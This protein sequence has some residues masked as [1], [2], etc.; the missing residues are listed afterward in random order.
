M[1]KIKIVYLS[2]FVHE[3][4]A[5]SNRQLSF[6]L[7]GSSNGRNFS[8]FPA[9]SGGFSFF[10]LSQDLGLVFLRQKVKMLFTSV[11]WS[12]FVKTVPSVLTTGLGS[13]LKTSDTILPIMDLPVGE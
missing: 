13:V 12:V 10:G 6:N 3:N 7:I 1:A 5:I 11:G 8:I 4:G 9:N 2:S